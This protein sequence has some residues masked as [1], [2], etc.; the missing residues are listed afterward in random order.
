MITT[1]NHIWDQQEIIPYLD[2]DAPVLRPLNF[3][4]D[5]PGRGCAIV[6]D[7]LVVN[8]IGRVFM[9]DYDCPFRAMDGLLNGS[10]ELPKVTL[11]DFHGEA[12]SEKGAM[13]WYL[14]GRVSAVVGTHTHVGT[15]DTMILPE[16]TAYVTDLGMVGPSESIIGDDPA[17]NYRAVSYADE[18]AY[19]RGQ[20]A[21]AVQ[22][23]ADRHRRVYGEG[24]GH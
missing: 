15:V 18:P 21:S 1:G 11:V 7:V 23:G 20:R 2:T 10:R 12:T 9:K 8:L 24:H 5:L 14:N 17:A 19:E 22:L 16:G 6:Q 13:G 3:P 4:P